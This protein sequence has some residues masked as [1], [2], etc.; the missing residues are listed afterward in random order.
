[1]KEEIR[2]EQIS[3][4]Y[5][6]ALR[7]EVMWPDKPIEYVQLPMDYQGIHWGLYVQN[8]LTSVISMFEQ[9]AGDFQFRKFATRTEHQGKGYGSALLRAA[10]EW[11]AG[12]GAHRIWCNARVIKSEFYRRFGMA[13]TDSTFTKG[14]INYVIMEKILK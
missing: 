8:E 13:E 3:A 9:E 4:P 10:F 7:H 14:G 1:M 12:Q 6:W 11:I 5:T 2:I